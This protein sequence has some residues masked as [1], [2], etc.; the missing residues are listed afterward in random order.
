MAINCIVKLDYDT[1]IIAGVVTDPEI[2]SGKLFES[3]EDAISFMQAHGLSYTIIEYDP[4][5][6]NPVYWVEKVYTSETYIRNPFM[7]AFL[8]LF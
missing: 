5:H 1:W 3:S 2:T 6:P 8:D 7:K 4:F